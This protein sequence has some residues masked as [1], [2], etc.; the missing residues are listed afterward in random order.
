MTQ[1]QETGNIVVPSVADRNGNLADLA[2]Q[3]TGKVSSDYWASQ[4]AQ[5][6]GYTVNAGEPYY[7]AGCNNTAQC[8]FPN[9]TI[10]MS[11]W[12]A[13]AKSL[14]QYIPQPNVGSDLF[15]VQR[16]TRPCPTTKLPC[17]LT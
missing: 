5:K 13:P 2:S 4:L 11:L 17:A 14:M 16:R 3:L 12:S 1:G 10:P 8:V 7:T 9:A 15:P 6:L